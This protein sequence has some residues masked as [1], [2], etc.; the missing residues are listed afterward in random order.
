MLDIN[1]VRRN[2]TKVSA[3]MILDCLKKVSLEELLAQLYLSNKSNYKDFVN[4]YE[5]IFTLAA[6]NPVR[7]KEILYKEFKSNARL[8]KQQKLYKDFY[9]F[10][11]DVINNC[12]LH[13]IDYWISDA[14]VSMLMEQSSYL[15]PQGKYICG[16]D[17]NGEPLLVNEPFPYTDYPFIEYEEDKKNKRL[18]GEMTLDRV[19]PYFK[20][21]G[22]IISDEEGMNNLFN[23]ERC[24]SNMFFN[25]KSFIDENSYDIVPKNYMKEPKKIEFDITPWKDT[26]YLKELLTERNY[27]LPSKG[28]KI[29]TKNIHSIKSVL[30]KEVQKNDSLFLLYKIEFNNG[31]ETSG[32]YDLDNELFYSMFNIFECVIYSIH[33]NL[34]NFILELYCL[35]TVDMEVDID[36]KGSIYVSKNLE[37]DEPTYYN[38]RTV[39]F[40]YKSTRNKTKGEKETFSNHYDKSKYIKVKKT[41]KETIRKLPNGYS[42]SEEAIKLARSKGYT[43]KPGETFVKSFDRKV[44][45]KK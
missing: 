17:T 23:S 40:L 36:D 5:K 29:L 21:Y 27:V 6:V 7:F 42:A 33:D 3:F 9:E 41:L 30:F 43:L 12:T 28:I 10:T 25:L 15:D 13:K 38:Q 32:Y 24:T 4:F 44:T 22:Y 20:K 11:H 34:E 35:L 16:V 45:K 37:I 18:K 26:I 2:R 1:K 31:E 19:Y 14:Y 8:I 39:Q